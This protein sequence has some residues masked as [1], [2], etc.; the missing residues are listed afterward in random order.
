MK[1]DMKNYRSECCKCGGHDYVCCADLCEN[2]VKTPGTGVV[3]NPVCPDCCTCC[4]EDIARA[5]VACR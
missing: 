5:N 2:D 4:E 3:H 1:F